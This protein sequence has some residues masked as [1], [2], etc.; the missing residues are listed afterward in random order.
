MAEDMILDITLKV[1]SLKLPPLPR[2]KKDK[3]PTIIVI[4]VITRS[5]KSHLGT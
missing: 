2:F 5:A 3:L 4:H 1:L